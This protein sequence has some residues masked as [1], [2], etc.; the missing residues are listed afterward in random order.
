MTKV[1]PTGSCGT[2]D[3]T[4]TNC[5]HEMTA[6]F[7]PGLV[8]V[9][10]PVRNRFD[11]LQQTLQSVYDQTYRPLEVIVMDDGSSEPIDPIIQ[12]FSFPSDTGF[13]IVCVRLESLGAPVARSRGCAFSRGEFIQFLDSD[14][15]MTPNKID[16]QVRALTIRQGGS[17]TQAVAYGPWRCLYTTVSWSRLGPPYQLEAMPSEEAMLLGYIAGHWFCPLHSYLFSRAT[18]LAV[19]R[20]DSWLARGQDT[21]YLIR[22]LLANV[23]FRFVPVGEAHYRRHPHDHIGAEQH[24]TTGLRSN[25]ELVARTFQRIGDHDGPQYRKALAARLTSLARDAA[26]RGESAG[27]AACRELAVAILGDHRQSADS[28]FSEPS[29]LAPLRHAISRRVRR[30]I[31]DWSIAWIRHA[32]SP[33][34]TWFKG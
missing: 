7:E 27:I 19:G 14:D 10:I 24:F 25:L 13:T 18:V 5:P 32:I 33:K 21:D 29:R 23:P 34:H 17:T 26:R 30:L 6:A 4:W 2:P 8:S 22:T 28:P 20:W 11:L 31:G 15:V 9:V 12:R 16:A 1:T 3:L